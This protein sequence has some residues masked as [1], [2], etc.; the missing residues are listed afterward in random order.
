MHL[1]LMHQLRAAREEPGAGRHDVKWPLSVAGVRLGG[2][3]G[4][5]RRRAHSLYVGG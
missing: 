5:C 2:W 1:L 4:W 3:R